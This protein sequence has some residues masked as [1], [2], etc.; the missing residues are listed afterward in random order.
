MP[1]RKAIAT[2]AALLLT[3]LVAFVHFFDANRLRGPLEANLGKRLG[4]RVSAGPM[5][6]K[7]FPL[8]L[9]VAKEAQA[10][11]TRSWPL[12]ADTDATNCRVWP[13]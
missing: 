9:R 13:G 1:H 10:K 11:V 2:A 12:A 6:L 3:A 4:R 5:S 8:S 7:L